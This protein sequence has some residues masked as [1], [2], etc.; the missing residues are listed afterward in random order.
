VA[1]GT[2]S[3]LLKRSG[4]ALLDTIGVLDLARA[5]RQERSV[6]LT[7]HGVLSGTDD[8][9]DFLN[10][11]FVAEEAFDRHLRF[12]T[13]HYRPIS[14]KDL[15]ACYRRNV[16]PPPR[17]IALT[18]DD[19]FANNCTVA[20]PLLRRYSIP[21]TVFLTTELIDRPGAQLW[22]ERVKR[23]V[24]L[25]PEGSVTIRLLDRE[26]A[27]D[28]RSP[29]AREDSARRILQILKRQAPHVRDESVEKIETVCGRPPLATADGERYTFLTWTQVKDMAAA[30]VEF[31]SHTV[32]HPILT[33][34]DDETLARELRHSKEQ[35]EEALGVECYAFAYPNGSAADYGVREKCALRQ[36]GYACGLSLRNSLN[37]PS[38]D[39]YE[40]DRVNIGRQFDPITFHAALTGVLGGARR[41]RDLLARTR[42]QRHAGAAATQLR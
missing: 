23:A 6:V 10:H 42:P 13:S 39:M 16:A 35:I 19:G 37:G 26:F 29:A 4:L 32:S 3:S 36:A 31:G 30:G 2:R 24:Y 41:V 14:L 7:Y 38:P 18:F 12:I 25:Y 22:T 21:F 5:W 20:F 17:S 9:N 28:L 40:I 27:C 11:N 34:L 8:T 15:V 1:A 33:T